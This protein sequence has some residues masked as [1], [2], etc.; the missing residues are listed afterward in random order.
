MEVTV[1]RDARIAIAC[2]LVCRGMGEVGIE[3]WVRIETPPLGRV[4]DGVA[5]REV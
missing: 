2:R 1:C 5:G 4:E 3:G